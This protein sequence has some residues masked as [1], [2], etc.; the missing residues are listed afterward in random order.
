MGR[1]STYCEVA[2]LG[3][4]AGQSLADMVGQFLG[5]FAD[6]LGGLIVGLVLEFDGHSGEEGGGGDG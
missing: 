5:L 3:V 6:G 2:G 4:A 1:F